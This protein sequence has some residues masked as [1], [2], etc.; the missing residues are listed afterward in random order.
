MFGLFLDTP[1][2]LQKMIHGPSSVKSRDI[3]AVCAGLHFIVKMRLLSLQDV[4]VQF[5]S[6]IQTFSVTIFNLY[7]HLND[8][9]NTVHRLTVDIKLMYI[10][11]PFTGRGAHKVLVGK[12]YHTTGYSHTYDIGIYQMRCTAYKVAPECGLIQSETCRAYIENKV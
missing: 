7:F 8:F 12:P 11:L 1:R 9:I 2:I 4:W 5:C 10:C 3:F 6:Y